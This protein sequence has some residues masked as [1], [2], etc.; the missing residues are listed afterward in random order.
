MFV[1]IQRGIIQARGDNK[2]TLADAHTLDP[3]TTP[4]RYVL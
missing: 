1:L 4:Y 2:I 3:P